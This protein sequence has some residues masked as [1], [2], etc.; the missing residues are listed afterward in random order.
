MAVALKSFEITNVQV[1]TELNNDFHIEEA[2]PIDTVKEKIA[3]Y[4]KSNLAVGNKKDARVEELSLNGTVV[5]LKVWIQS[6]HKE[7]GVTLYSVSYELKGTYDL[8]NSDSIGESEICF[9]TPLGKQCIK[10]KQIVEILK[11]LL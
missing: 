7:F 1:E 8:L 10:A 3:D 9:D 6:K 4:C 5:T 2:L 11:T